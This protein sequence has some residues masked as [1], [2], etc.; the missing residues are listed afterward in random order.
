MADN[1][2]LDKQGFTPIGTVITGMDLLSKVN[3]PTPDNLFGVDQNS[4]KNSG[5]DWL[6]ENYPDITMIVGKVEPTKTP[7]LTPT[8]GPSLAPGETAPPS[9][10]PSSMPTSVPSCS[11]SNCIEKKCYGIERNRDYQNCVITCNK[12]ACSGDDLGNWPKH[13]EIEPTEIPTRKPV[14]VSNDNIE[15][16]TL[17]HTKGMS[18]GYTSIVI[19]LILATA[20]GLYRRYSRK[21][22]SDSNSRGEYEVVEQDDIELSSTV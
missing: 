5:N 11:L 22:S 4:Y 17:K 13:I 15:K 16:Q 1:S 7:S 9:F 3:N 2:Y 10:T 18:V 20:L 12:D 19:L 8:L 21:H 14:Y 6:L